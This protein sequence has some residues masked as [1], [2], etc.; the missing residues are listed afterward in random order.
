MVEVDEAGREPEAAAVHAIGLAREVGTRPEQPRDPPRFQ[1]ERAAFGRR[2]LGIQQARVGE[3]GPA[4]G[5][6]GAYRGR[7]PGREPDAADRG[8]AP[9]RPARAAPIREG[10]P[11]SAW[12]P[13]G[14]GA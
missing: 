12:A 6:R 2:A 10:W 9:S 8:G 5:G 11:G 14:A 13:R 7:P 3:D 1:D 4:H